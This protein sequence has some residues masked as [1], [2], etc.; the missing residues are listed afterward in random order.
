MQPIT[1]F[2]APLEFYLFGATLLGVARKTPA[3]VT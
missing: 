3:R 1:L 2:N